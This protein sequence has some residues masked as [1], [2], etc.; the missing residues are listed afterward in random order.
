MCTINCWQRTVSGPSWTRTFPV[1]VTRSPW[2]VK[3]SDVTI[4]VVF[5]RGG[6]FVL[7]AL[8]GVIE[9]WLVMIALFRMVAST[10]FEIVSN[11]RLGSHIQPSPL[12]LNF[13]SA[14][15]TESAAAEFATLFCEL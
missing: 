7:A 9:G 12:M 11:V 8:A 15:F 2:W 1:K 10:L 5:V 14:P 6:W 4:T 13:S 3:K